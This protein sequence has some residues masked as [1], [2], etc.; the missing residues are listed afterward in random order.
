MS[1][2]IT[3]MGCGNSSGVPAIGNFWGACD[4]QEPRNKRTRCALAVQ[5]ENTTLILDT[6]SDFREQMN[7]HHISNL[8]AVLYTHPHSDHCHGIDDLRGFFFRQGRKAL[9]VYGSEETLADITKRFDYLFKGGNNEEFYPPMLTTH[10]YAKN[11]YGRTQCVGDIEFIPYKID[12]GSCI[13]TGY[14]FGD[15]AYSVDMKTMDETALNT[16]AGVK[17][18]VVDGAAYKN[19]DNAVHAD[20][21]TIYRYNKIIKAKEVYISSLS[22]I[23]DYQTLRTELPKGFYPAYDGLVF[24][25]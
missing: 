19:P 8:S 22:T 14:R 12:H 5:S 4:P 1:L 10:T 21:E 24:E 23:M 11:M 18:W 25:I 13:V 16:I 17:I 3:I 2:K 7:R 15:F 6:G 9:D 20:L